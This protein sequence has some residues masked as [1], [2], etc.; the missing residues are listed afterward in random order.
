[1]ILRKHRPTLQSLAAVALTTALL[2]GGVAGCAPL[3]F[4][5]AVVGSGLVVSDRR[6]AGTQLEDEAIEIKA[7]SRARELATLGHI[8]AISYNRTLLLVGEVPTD[9]DKAAVGQAVSRIENVRSVVNELAAMPN[10]SVGNRSNDAI[11]SGK[12]KA[13]FVD[14]KDLQSNAFKV[15]TDRGI[16]YLMGRVTEREATRGADLSRAIPGVQKV[17]R[18]FEILSEDELAALSR[19]GPASAPK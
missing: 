14:A 4:G 9:A 13:T 1:M 10:S 3:L 12:V 17:V 7:A 15:V 16:V 5:G 18:V 2:A 19:Q 6:T 8:N 11:L